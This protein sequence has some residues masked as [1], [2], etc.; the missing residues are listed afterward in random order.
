MSIHRATLLASVLVVGLGS[1]AGTGPAAAGIS[2]E[3][4]KHV[5]P[6]YSKCIRNVHS[7][8]L[9]QYRND[10]QINDAA[11]NACNRSHPMFGQG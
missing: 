6:E 8:L 5:N 2:F 10:A 7:Q 11:V 4:L 3:F 9:P 1:L